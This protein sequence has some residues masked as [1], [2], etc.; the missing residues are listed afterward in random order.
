M[1]TTIEN[2]TFDLNEIS[3]QLAHQK[4][5]N[6][7]QEA[8]FRLFSRKISAQQQRTRLFYLKEVNY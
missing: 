5:I 4:A 7:R 1:Q 8:D 6:E 2:L 3:E